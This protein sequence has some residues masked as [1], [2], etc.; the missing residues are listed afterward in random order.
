MRNACV[1]LRIKANTRVLC[2][3]KMI[4]HLDKF[5]LF[6]PLMQRPKIFIVLIYHARV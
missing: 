5:P 1:I 3:L 2:P 6:F 4:C